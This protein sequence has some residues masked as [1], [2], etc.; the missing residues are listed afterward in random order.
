VLDPANGPTSPNPMANNP[1]PMMNSD[2]S[3]M[4]YQRYQW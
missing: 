2:F 3:L 1:M 4:S